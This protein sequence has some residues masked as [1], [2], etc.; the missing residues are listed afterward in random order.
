LA[1]FLGTLPMLGAIAVWRYPSLPLPSIK[2]WERVFGGEGSGLCAASGR[3]RE[4]E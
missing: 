1:S 3:D 2:F 4:G